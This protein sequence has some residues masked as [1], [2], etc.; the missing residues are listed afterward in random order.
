MTLYELHLQRIERIT[1]SESVKNHAIKIERLLYERESERETDR[2][3]AG[4]KN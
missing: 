4:P 1:G 2:R 3:N